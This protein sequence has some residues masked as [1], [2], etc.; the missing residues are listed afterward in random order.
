MAEIEPVPDV[1]ISKILG[2]LE[3]LDDRGGR[4]D[5]YKLAEDLKMEMGEVL[6]LMRAAELLRLVETPGGDVVLLSEGKAMIE[7]EVN[8]K[9][10]LLKNCLLS[11]PLFAY[12]V[13]ILEGLEGKRAK[14]KE[15]IKI[16]KRLLVNENPERIFR[17]LVDWG[18][19]AELFGYNPDE[20]EFYLDTA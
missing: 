15:M 7:A 9:K 13:H 5:I 17:I 2:F 20:Q 16:V 4:E 14:K 10:S 8:Q 11:I 3:V 6:N 12:F 19:Y 1:S 18:R